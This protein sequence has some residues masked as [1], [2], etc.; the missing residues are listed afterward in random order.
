M[1]QKY[2]NKLQ[3]FSFF[4]SSLPLPPPTAPPPPQQSP[5]INHPPKKT[6]PNPLLALS[7]NFSAWTI[8]ICFPLL[9]SL[10]GKIS[11]F[12]C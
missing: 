10:K 8:F 3:F 7:Q 11:I 12:K 2:Q 4:K 9:P 6:L 5:L 1:I